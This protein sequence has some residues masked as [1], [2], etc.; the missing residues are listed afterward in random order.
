MPELGTGELVTC[1]SDLKLTSDMGVT[2]GATYK[3]ISNKAGTINFLNDQG[4]LI[5]MAAW[6]FKRIDNNG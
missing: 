1:T 3:V 4:K 5:A 6:R 2:L